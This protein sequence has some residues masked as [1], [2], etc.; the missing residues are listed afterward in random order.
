MPMTYPL[1]CEEYTVPA[2]MRSSFHRGRE[3]RRL[4]AIISEIGFIASLLL[5]F[6]GLAAVSQETSETQ[7]SKRTDAKVHT[8]DESVSDV[9]FTGW[10]S[11][12]VKAYKQ[13]LDTE[14]PS[15][16][17]VVTVPRLHLHAP[18]FEGRDDAT[19]DRGLGRIP[20]TAYPGETGNL[21]VAGHRDGFF[22]PLKDIR[23]GDI[24]EVETPHEIGTYSVD[25]V[26]IVEPDNIQVLKSGP[27]STLTL[28]TCYPFYFIGHAPK[29]F[30]VE[31]SLIRSSPHP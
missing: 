15:P 24:V 26:E 18:L 4:L 30:I 6:S 12:R 25:R 14:F 13:A 20:G 27:K 1:G 10:S 5:S 7:S 29:R 19:L 17:A 22:R 23:V 16:I 3:Y 2:G 28:V 11:I 8:E 31:A 21:G 9:D